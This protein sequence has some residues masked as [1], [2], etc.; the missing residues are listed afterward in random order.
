MLESSLSQEI[1][2][3][4]ETATRQ[5]LNQVS[6]NALKFAE[7]KYPILKSYILFPICASFGVGILIY[8]TFH[9]LL[10]AFGGF[11][12]SC[13]FFL[14]LTERIV[15]RIKSRFLDQAKK[16]CIGDS[17]EGLANLAEKKLKFELQIARASLGDA[18]IQIR[19]LKAQ[20]KALLK[21]L[22]TDSKRKFI[23]SNKFYTSTDW[24]NVRDSRLRSSPNSCARCNSDNDLTVDHIKPRSKFPE[25]ALD[26]NNTQILC[27]SCN[28]S[29]GYR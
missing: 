29:K 20:I 22:L 12:F 25:L 15:F 28:S 4:R 27:R 2:K 17:L 16:R 1:E 5:Y 6:I 24:I 11:S 3:T 18:L 26:L 14:G 19:E 23:L 21:S 7:D 9:Q 8:C 13:L 10:I